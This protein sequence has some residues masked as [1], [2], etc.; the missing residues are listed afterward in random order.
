MIM[1]EKLFQQNK[2]KFA[3]PKK[4]PLWYLKKNYQWVE[5]D[6][7][8]WNLLGKLMI[9]WRVSIEANTLGITICIEL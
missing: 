8:A 3:H 1:M 7:W 6:T 9:K 4:Q 2:L 5:V